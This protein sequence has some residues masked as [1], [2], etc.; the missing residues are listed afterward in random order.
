MFIVEFGLVMLLRRSCSR[1][2]TELGEGGHFG[3]ALVANDLS[4]PITAV[5]NSQFVKVRTASL[6]R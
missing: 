3:E 1:M 5:A 6:S 4:Q 2:L